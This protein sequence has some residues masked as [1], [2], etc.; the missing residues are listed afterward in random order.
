MCMYDEQLAM[1]TDHIIMW[2]QYID[3]M[4]MIWDGPE[5]PLLAYLERLNR[6]KFNLTFTMSHHPNELT[7]LDV[8]V[9]RGEDHTIMT[10]LY[11]KPTAGNC[12]AC[13]KLSSRTPIDLNSL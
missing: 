6:K 5:E 11:P 10:R 3:D 9:I 13:F 4:F 12:P 1:Y 7:F 8:M 2:H